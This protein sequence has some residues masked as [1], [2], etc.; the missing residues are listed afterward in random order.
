LH[1][2]IARK[3]EKK[4]LLEWGDISVWF[5]FAFSFYEKCLFRSTS[6][7]HPF[8][9]KVLLYCSDWPHSYNPAFASW[10]LGL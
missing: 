5:W 9:T 7:P 6:P 8:E 1:T 10:V 2:S 4:F 3:K